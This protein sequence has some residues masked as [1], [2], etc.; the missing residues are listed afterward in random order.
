MNAKF[1]DYVKSTAFNLSL[2]KRQVET[3]LLMGKGGFSLFMYSRLDWSTSS[4]VVQL[5]NLGQK[6]LITKPEAQKP[7]WEL[8][9]EGQKVY[10]LL[11]LAG[12]ELPA[13]Y[14]DEE[15]TVPAV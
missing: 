1:A 15:Q 9:P 11:L 6:G 14:G 12:Y 3:L 2:S 7:G 8:T 13:G 10:E 4:G 5:L